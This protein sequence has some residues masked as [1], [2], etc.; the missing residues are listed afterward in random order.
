MIDADNEDFLYFKALLEKMEGQPFTLDWLRK[1]DEVQD[2]GTL[3]EYDVILSITDE[4]EEK[5]KPGLLRNLEWGE[6]KT[7]ILSLAS[8]EF[9]TPLTSIASSADLLEAYI[10]QGDY[11]K[12]E[13]HVAR[14]K[15]SVN[16][17]DL[18]L[19]RVLARG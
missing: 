16:E 19:N 10:K 2:V 6:L 4:A 14:I 12:V 15:K 18:L 11:D 1:W 3:R 7:R 8:H 17:M 9:R 13:K 5:K